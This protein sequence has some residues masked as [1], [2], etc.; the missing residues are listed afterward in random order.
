MDK[1][2]DILIC[3]GILLIGGLIGYFIHPKCIEIPN[4]RTDTVFKIDTIRDTVLI[5]KRIIQTKTIVDTL[6]LAGRVDT[7]YVNVEIPIETKI[8]QTNDYK[9][10]I[11]GYKP[12]LNSIE[13]YRKT[14][15]ITEYKNII[16]YRNKKWGAGLHMGYSYS[17][18]VNKFYPT[19]SVGVNYN[20]IT[21]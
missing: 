18:L 3:L 8:Y 11:E 20:L 1:L 12:N 13:I 9:A 5:P 10:E 15:I 17:P 2:K 7:V 21:F 19:I 4:T 14:Q 16:E 6:K